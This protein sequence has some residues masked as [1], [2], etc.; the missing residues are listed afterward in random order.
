MIAKV[1]HAKQLYIDLENKNINL[2]DES[3][4]YHLNIWLSFLKSIK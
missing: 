4:D 3:S 1:E 2:F